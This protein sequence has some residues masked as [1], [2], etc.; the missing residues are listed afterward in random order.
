[1]R[2]PRAA[3]LDLDGTLVDSN[4]QHALAWYRAFR[5]AGIVLPVWKLHRAVGMGG[6]QL[7]K[8]MTSEE[9]DAQ[10]G[11]ELRI[12]EKA[13]FRQMIWECEP[14]P[15]ARELL[16]E[17]RRR[18]HKVVLASSANE[19][20]LGHFLD[21]LDARDVAD[22][23]TTADD[24]ARSK[25]EPDVVHAAIEK[26]GVAAKDAVMIGDSRWDV[27]A[28]KA[29]KVQTIAVLTGGWAREELLD[30]GAAMVFESLEE[31]RERLDE[32]PLG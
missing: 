18:G 21:K 16:A 26:A 20:D 30:A 23:W 1:V 17:L 32:T 19:Q 15:G 31:L 14:L 10:L 12:A 13:L 5:G 22:G 28:A 4:Y 24:V 9:L 29:A 6:D 8:A 2:L 25:P 11:E 27:E 7:V 3:L